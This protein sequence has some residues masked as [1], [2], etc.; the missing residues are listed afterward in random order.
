MAWYSPG[1]IAKTVGTGIVSLPVGATKGVYDYAVKPG[2]RA[3]AG[4]INKFAPQGGSFDVNKA[5]QD[6]YQYDPAA[7]QLGPIDS[8]NAN[9][10]RA[11]MASFG[12]TLRRRASGEVPS[13]AEAQLRQATTQNQRSLASALSGLSGRNA[14]LGIRGL[15]QQ[16]AQ[17]GQ[18]VAGQA[19]LLRAQEQA[20]AEQQLANYYGQVAQRDLSAQE[21]AFKQA[22]A[23]QQARQALQE[24]RGRDIAALLGIQAQASEGANN[25]RAD[26]RNNLIGGIFGAGGAAIGSG[27]TS[28]EK[29]KKEI[30]GAAG[31]AKKFLDELTAKTFKYKGSDEPMMGVMAQDAEKSKMGKYLVEK[32]GGYKA[33]NGKKTMSAMLASL[34]Y[35]NDRLNK[36]EGK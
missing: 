26:F 30:K 15:Q 32:K 2:G 27:V 12:E 35:L 34:A 25:R 14:A 20:Q 8:Q 13:L 24:S 11:M 10:S 9:E 4:Q 22:L 28:D 23:Q 5:R 18:D 31:E 1:K 16:F 6:L 36:M 7:Y 17:Q 19:A 21:L 33:L 29:A 3:I